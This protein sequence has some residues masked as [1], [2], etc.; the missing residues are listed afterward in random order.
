M[1]KKNLWWIPII[2]FVF[3]FTA[4]IPAFAVDD[5]PVNIDLGTLSEGSSGDGYS[6]SGGLL[7]I[8]GSGPFIIRSSVSTSNRVLVNAPDGVTSDITALDLKISSTTEGNCAFALTDNSKVELTL[9]GNNELTSGSRRAGLEVPVGTELTVSGTPTDSLTVMGG[10]NA[11]GIGGGYTITPA[12]AG[13]ITISGS[14]IDATGGNADGGTGSGAGIGGGRG[15]S[16]GTITIEGGDITATGGYRASGIGGGTGGS[17]GIIS[18]IDGDITAETIDSSY[19]AGIGGGYDRGIDSITIEGGTI[20]ATGHDGA[21]IGGGR[22]QTS[23]SSSD[24]GTINISGG[25]ITATSMGG[26]GIGGGLLL[27]TTY[28]MPTTINITGGTIDASSYSGAGIGSNEGVINISGGTIVAESTYYGAGIGGGYLRGSGTI[29]ISGGIITATGAPTHG[30]AG[31]GSGCNQSDSSIIAGGIINISGGVITASG[32]E[33][34]AGIG[35]SYS[36]S[37]GTITITGGTINAAGGS[38]GAGIGVGLGGNGGEIVISQAILNVSYADISTRDTISAGTTGSV[39]IGFI[40][41]PDL[42]EC[43]PFDT[44]AEIT[45]A[46]GS[47]NPPGLVLGTC[48]IEGAGEVDGSY[49]EGVKI[50]EPPFIGSG[51]TDDPFQLTTADQLHQIRDYLDKS[52][53]LENDIDAAPFNSGSGW[54]PIGTSESPFTGNIDGNDHT[55]NNLFINRNSTTG[56]GLFGYISGAELT[57]IIINNANVI[58]NKEIGILAGRATN[59]VISNSYVNGTVS[60]TDTFDIV[61]GLIGNVSSTTISNSKAAVTVS[62]HQ[63]VGG[64]VGLLN[65]DAEILSCQSEGTVSA[66]D[67]VGGL[68]GINFGRIRSSFS[69]SDVSGSEYIGGLAGYNYWGGINEILNSYARGSVTGT[70]YVGGL[71]GYNFYSIITNCYST[72]LVNGSTNTGGLVGVSDS[73]TELGAITG[74]YYDSLTSSQLDIGKGQPKTTAEM[75]TQDTFVDWEF[76]DIWTRNDTDNNGYPALA[77]QGFIH[78][79]PS[80]GKFPWTMF[81]PAITH[82]V[83]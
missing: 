64:L 35:S 48:L 53:V 46:N 54:E 10:Y 80:D 17:S 23:P 58:G 18:I 7:T 21:G 16:G 49:I 37:T 36:T 29:N 1:R 52:F 30:G 28:V 42:W 39:H 59:S 40:G 70:K 62:G 9:S 13:I 20:V 2:A 6:F 68:V 31:I 41:D 34:A 19:S 24:G 83:Q 27:Y 5:V 78:E 76:P 67:Y 82:K 14:V 25:D 43:D 55:I 26:A 47:L 11:A 22:I 73:D 71:A 12:Q 44:R 66:T 45:L 77:W 4:I 56:V 15:G 63:R 50:V 74:S 75:K 72:G 3:T 81:L 60:G 32:G 57:N 65:S 38:G 51:T 8:T 79:T 61:G 69:T 33:Y